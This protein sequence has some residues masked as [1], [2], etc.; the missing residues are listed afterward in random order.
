M[1]ILCVSHEFQKEHE[2]FVQLNWPRFNTVHWDYI[3]IIVQYIFCGIFVWCDAPWDFSNIKYGPWLR[4]VWKYCATRT[5]NNIF[6]LWFWYKY[7]YRA[8]TIP[9]RCHSHPSHVLQFSTTNLTNLSV[10]HSLGLFIESKSPVKQISLL[11]LYQSRMLPL[12]PDSSKAA[13]TVRLIITTSPECCPVKTFCFSPAFVSLGCIFMPVEATAHPTF[14]KSL[15]YCNKS[16]IRTTW[17]KK[18]VGEGEEPGGVQGEADL[19]V[20][21]INQ[22][23]EKLSDLRASLSCVHINF[24]TCVFWKVMVEVVL[25]VLYI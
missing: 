23:A 3:V 20:E 22:R 16:R 19:W 6:F 25:S 15:W 18:A 24:T 2:L 9:S 12:P 7:I 5:I 11:I 14:Q 21:Q 10:A 13:C 1:S 8:S 17:R 4:N